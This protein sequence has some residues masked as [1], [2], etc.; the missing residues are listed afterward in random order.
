M[1]DYR[2]RAD[3]GFLTAG[4]TRSRFPAWGLDGGNDGSPNYIEFIPKSG[5]RKKFAFTSGLPTSK[6]DIIRVVTGSG[7]GLGNP[8]ERDPD[9]VRED[10][11]N[12]LL[13]SGRAKEVFGVDV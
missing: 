6:D 10:V 7:G 9:Q 12:G 3:D 11:R 13:T 5:E 2:I 4:Y 8:A 1:L